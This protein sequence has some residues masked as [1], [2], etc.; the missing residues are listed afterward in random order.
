MLNNL[1]KQKKYDEN[2]SDLKNIAKQPRYK[3]INNNKNKDK[4]ES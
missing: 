3:N 1:N 4:E 2:I